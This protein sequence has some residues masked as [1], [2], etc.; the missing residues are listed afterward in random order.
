MKTEL[1]SLS[2]A[3]EFA[4]LEALYDSPLGFNEICAK[5]GYHPHTRIECSLWDL[6]DMELI[7]RL[8]GSPR[9]S[10][11]YCLTQKGK[12]FI[13]DVKGEK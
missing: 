13:N 8:A 1:G 5:V 11:A 12:D 3:R 4:M 10:V 7:Q 6:E 9:R 2:A